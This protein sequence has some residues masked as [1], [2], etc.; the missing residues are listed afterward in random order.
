MRVSEDDV[1]E[2]AAYTAQLLN[3]LLVGLDDDQPEKLSVRAFESGPGEWA[4]MRRRSLLSARVAGRFPL[5][6]GVR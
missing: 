6:G 5:L 2:A 1:N 3:S 4:T